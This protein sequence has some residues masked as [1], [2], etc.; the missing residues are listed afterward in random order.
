MGMKREGQEERALIFWRITA[1][2]A[3]LPRLGYEKGQ[4]KQ[5]W[6]WVGEVPAWAVEPH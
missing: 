5:A 6:G 2:A 3:G 4:K 1:A